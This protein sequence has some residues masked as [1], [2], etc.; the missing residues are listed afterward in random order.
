[1]KG[2]TQIH[3]K[4]ILFQKSWIWKCPKEEP[5]EIFFE[6]HNKSNT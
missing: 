4:N 1:M 3:K 5:L 6:I 2:Y